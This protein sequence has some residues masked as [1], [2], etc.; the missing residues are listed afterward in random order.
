MYTS[1]KSEAANSNKSGFSGMIVNSYG[2]S[3]AG[4][5]MSQ[6]TQ[7]TAISNNTTEGTAGGQEH[8]LQLLIEKM[9]SLPA[10][11]TWADK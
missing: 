5:S 3:G 10:N 2:G 11:A 4:L 9:Q 6:K 1:S 7:T 8:H